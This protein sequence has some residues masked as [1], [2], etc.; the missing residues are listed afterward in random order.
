MNV[1]IQY[2]DV[3]G[4]WYTVSSCLNEGF[5]IIEAMKSASNFYPG[6]RIRAIDENGR[7]VDLL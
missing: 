6:C 7:I 3:T 5:Y 4:S 1:N 2:Q